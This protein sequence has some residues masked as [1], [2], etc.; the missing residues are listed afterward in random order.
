LS[1]PTPS[2]SLHTNFCLLCTFEVLNILLFE[3]FFISIGWL[4]YSLILLQKNLKFFKNP[5][6]FHKFWYSSKS[7]YSSKILSF[8]NNRHILQKSSN[9]VQN[10][11]ILVKSS[12]SSKCS[13]ISK[14]NYLKIFPKSSY[15]SKIFIVLIFFKIFIYSSY[16]SKIFISLSPGILIYRSEN[17]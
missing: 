16:S 14:K 9:I 4:R 8:F 3:I 12:Y 17:V 7:S 5:Q 2:G 10:F 13:K 1:L 15:P 11:N 6:V